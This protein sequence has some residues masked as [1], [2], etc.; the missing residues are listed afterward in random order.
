MRMGD[1]ASMPVS[2]PVWISTANMTLEEVVAVSDGAE[3]H[4]ADDALAVI[5]D[6]RRVIDEAIARGDAIY[7][8]T[9]GVGHARD[10]RLPADAL[11]AM[12]P[13]LIEMHVGGMGDPLAP[14]RVRAGLV[15]RLNG[16][17]RG[18]AGA[19]LE[20]AQG[21]AALLNHRIHPVIP[22]RGSVGAGDLGQLALVG[23]VL[24]GR[25]E[26]EVAGR[27]SDAMTALA[28]AGLAPLELQPK[29]ALALIS[30]NA[31]SIGHGALVVHRAR[32]VLNLADLVAAVSMEATH[33]NPSIL[34]PAVASVRGSDGQQT[35]SDRMRRA[36]RGSARTD[37]AAG[38]SV[39]DA[40]STRVVPQ[41]HGACRD[42]LSAMAGALTRE[43]NAAADNPL[44]D[45]A[46][47]TA[48]SNG[49]FH[50][51][52]VVLATESL[53][54]AL[55]HVGQLTERR[56]G[57][58]WDAAVTSMGIEGPPA[59]GAS[60]TRAGPPPVL[61]GLGLRY[62]AAAR[63]TRLRQLANPVS[64]DVPTLD[65]GVEDHAPN[66]AVAMSASE[67]AVAIVEE[68]LVTELLIAM[69][70]LGPD[71]AQGVGAG[72]AQVL[73]IVGEELERLPAGALPDAVHARVA[74]VLR[75]S[76]PSL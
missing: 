28:A 21:I 31:L 55:A 54:V 20:L 19:S 50:P 63:Y 9:T 2:S 49:N 30:S 14:D 25:S 67:E 70:L 62:P 43:L 37:A 65:L 59:A 32:H 5:A 48:I 10:E 22:D 47:G 69:V 56:M 57:H 46:S 60:P 76:L 36:L 66:T 24:L 7:G 64:L 40:L 42:V 33:G 75:E 1:T 52:N 4:L 13:V 11:R 8:V 3:V 73:G 35:T 41:V 34:D 53:R 51:M 23:R 61:A 45:V 44:V 17:A 38:V 6:S 58:V 71:A 18:G 16:I 27:R 12:Q 68:L 26:V 72:T 29:D 39:Q 15:A 74:A